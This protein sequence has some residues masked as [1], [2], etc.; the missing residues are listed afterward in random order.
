MVYKGYNKDFGPLT[1]AQIHRYCTELKRIMKDEKYNKVKIFHHCGVTY[2]KRANACL[3]M[4]SFLVICCGFS[5]EEAWK[6]FEVIT[7]DPIVAFWDA[8]ENPYGD[9]ACTVLDCLRGIK[10]AITLG[11]YNCLKFDYKEFELNHKLENGDMNWVLPK[12]I[13]A[14]SSPS[15]D[16]KDGLPPEF[17]YDKFQK[18][19]I[20]GIIRLNE[21]LYEE[22]KFRKQGINVYDLEFRDGSC[23]SDVCSL[24]S[25]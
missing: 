17:F 8:G 9:Y 18:M 7:V 11:W 1:L 12:K 14:L 3:L 15:D 4:C 23:P 6:P 5:P 2:N 22:D 20:R 16:E 25:N 10:K 19:K 13:L 21:M 24:T